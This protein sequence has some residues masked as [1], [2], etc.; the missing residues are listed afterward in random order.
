M[1]ILS[2]QTDR[3]LVD[4]APTITT[5]PLPVVTV[6]RVVSPVSHTPGRTAVMIVDGTPTDIT[7]GPPT[8]NSEK[9]IDYISVFNNDTVAH[10]VDVVLKVSTVD[11]I[12]HRVLLGQGEKLE[13]TD[14]QGFRVLANNGA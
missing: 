10:F 6:W 12:L 7:A 8:S 9:V 2:D 3:L 1:I 14:E 13:Y 5:N 11:Y 4:I